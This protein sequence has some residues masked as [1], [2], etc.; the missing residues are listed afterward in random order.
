MRVAI[1]ASAAAAELI[2]VLQAMRVPQGGS[3][4]G[5]GLGGIYVAY[6]IMSGVS[7]SSK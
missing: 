4:S 1:P 5:A 3:P 7:G 2:E 6:V